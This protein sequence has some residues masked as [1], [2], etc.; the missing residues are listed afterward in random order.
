MT[1]ETT[2]DIGA[3]ASREE[4][5]ADIEATREQLGETVSALGDKLD[6][7]SHVKDSAHQVTENVRTSSV[8]PAGVAGAFV[9]VASIVVWRRTR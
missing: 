1:D 9:V 2:P 8:M 6:V 7:K 3:G 4:I 5:V